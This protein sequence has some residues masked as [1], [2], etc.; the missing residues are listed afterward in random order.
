ME[1]NKQFTVDPAMDK[2]IGEVLKKLKRAR[3]ISGIRIFLFMAPFILVVLIARVSGMDQTSLHNLAQTTMI[4]NGL[5]VFITLRFFIM[6]CYSLKVWREVTE[7][8][9]TVSIPTLRSSRPII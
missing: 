9:Q 6:A 3:V 1:N 2:H 8:Y 4:L 5:L 7:E